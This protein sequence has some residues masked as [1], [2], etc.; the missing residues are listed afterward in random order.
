MG[1]ANRILISVLLPPR[2]LRS[3]F[4]PDDVNYLEYECFAESGLEFVKLPDNLEHLEAD[5]FMCCEKLMEIN[6]PKKLAVG[7]MNTNIF[8]SDLDFP[9]W[10]KSYN[11]IMKA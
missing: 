3:I 11:K 8:F 10:K 5:M 6:F 4:L 1:G 7:E 9:D 2:S